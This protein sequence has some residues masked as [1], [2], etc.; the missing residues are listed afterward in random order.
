MWRSCSLAS[1]T[2]WLASLCHIFCGTSL[3][4]GQWGNKLI[5]T[6]S[7]PCGRWIYFVVK[8]FHFFHDFWMHNFCLKVLEFPEEWFEWI[9]TISTY[10]KLGVSNLRDFYFWLSGTRVLPYW[11]PLDYQNIYTAEFDLSSSCWNKQ[12]W[13]CSEVWVVSCI[14]SASYFIL[15]VSCCCSS[16]HFQRKVTCVSVQEAVEIPLAICIKSV[17]VGLY[18]VIYVRSFMLSRHM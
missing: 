14:L 7:C 1:F 9:E 3:S 15:C 13:E 8:V 17:F 18:E 5:E 16:Y 12:D 10:F 2:C 6:R 11:F 4:I